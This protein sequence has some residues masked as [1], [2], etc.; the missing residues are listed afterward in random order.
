MDAEGWQEGGGCT[1]TA[2]P[3][4]ADGCVAERSHPTPE[5]DGNECAGDSRGNE[6]SVR[7]ARGKGETEDGCTGG[8]A[9]RFSA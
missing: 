9:G 3:P 2:V 4:P 7:L 5:A 1:D 8:K 6:A